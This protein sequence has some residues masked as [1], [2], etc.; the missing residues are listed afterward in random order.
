[1]RRLFALVALAALLPPPVRGADLEGALNARWRGSWALIE[2]AS[3]SECNSFYNDNDAHG[4][5]IDGGG[6]HRFAP[7]ELAHVERIGTKRG[8]IDVFLDI[9]EQVLA[10]RRDGPFTLY[11]PLHCKIQLK[12]P[13]PSS[14]TFEAAEAALAPLLEHFPSDALAKA[15]SHWNRRKREPYPPDY[16]RTLAEYEVWKAA[17]L[18]AAVQKRMDEAIEELA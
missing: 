14:V 1:M 4:T 9:V 16:D 7:G 5:R 8:R 13:V 15:S 17:Q 12:I 2:A 6:A 10:A 11:D 18:N 3:A